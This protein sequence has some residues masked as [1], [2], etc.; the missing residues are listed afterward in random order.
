MTN[1]INWGKD[2]E[3]LLKE[4]SDKAICYKWLHLQSYEKYIRKNSFF[5]IPIIVISTLSGVLNFTQNQI[6]LEYV[7]YYVLFIG[8]LNIMNGMLSTIHQYLKIAELSESHKIAYISWDKLYNNIKTE[9]SKNIKNRIP[10]IDFISYCKQEYNR[11][12]EIS[13][14]I[15]YDI[16]IMFH[17]TF[18]KDENLIIPDI[19][20]NIK[21]TNIFESSTPMDMDTIIEIDFLKKRT[22]ELEMSTKIENIKII[23]LQQKGRLPTQDEINNSIESS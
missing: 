20:G 9:L 14:I 1:D 5:I 10:L 8:G 16:L 23:F 3:L 17:N 7:N 18:E 13:P 19:L 15:N 22:K 21:S 2:T 4:W 12:L 6:P 11:L